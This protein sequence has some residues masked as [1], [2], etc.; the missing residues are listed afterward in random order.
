[1][2]V[3]AWPQPA[4]AG[5]PSVQLPFLPPAE[6]PPPERGGGGGSCGGAGTAANAR[7]DQL[8]PGSV[9]AGERHARFVPSSPRRRVQL[10]PAPPRPP[11]P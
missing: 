10:V 6:L 8:P 11:P 5:E 2:E 1:M 9:A 7:Y 4:L 3:G